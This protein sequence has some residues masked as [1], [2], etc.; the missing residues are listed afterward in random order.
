[1]KFDILLSPV[2]DMDVWGAVKG[3]YSF[4]ITKDRRNGNIRASAKKLEAKPFDHT[5]I[6][7]GAGFASLQAAESACRNWFREH[8]Q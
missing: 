1:M 8:A 6:D 2:E 7:I 5:R 4:V 3:P